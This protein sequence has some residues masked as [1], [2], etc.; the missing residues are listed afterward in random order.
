MSISIALAQ[1]QSQNETNLEFNITCGDMICDFNETV[2]CPQDCDKCLSDDDCEDGDKCTYD[3]C[4]GTPKECFHEE[5]KCEDNN[6]YTKDFCFEGECRYEQLTICESGDGL[7]PP[8]CSYNEDS[9]CSG[10]DLCANSAECEDNNP[11]TIDV[12]EGNPKRCFNRQENGC[13]YDGQCMKVGKRLDN[14]YCGLKNKWEKQ[15]IKNS[16]CYENYECLT[17]VCSGGECIEPAKEPTVFEKVL[18]ILAT[19]IG[20]FFGIFK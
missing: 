9:D 17:N 5:M 12:C 4:K 10:E 2:S 14:S 3:I 13:E 7:C 16:I 8:G 20:A 15:K 6:P 11:C 18:N 19:V 1:N